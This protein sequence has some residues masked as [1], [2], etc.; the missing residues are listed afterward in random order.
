MSEHG[1]SRGAHDPMHP[2]EV[3]AARAHAE[4]EQH[5]GPHAPDRT[6]WLIAIILGVITA[7]ETWTYFEPRI[8]RW[9]LIPFLLAMSGAK[10]ALV[11]AFFMHLKF[12]SKLFTGFFTFGI[13]VAAATIVSLIALFKGLW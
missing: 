8:P 7:V 9:F 5:E 4:A 13:A 3:R 6:Y 12:D 10:F 11:A 1:H 2:A